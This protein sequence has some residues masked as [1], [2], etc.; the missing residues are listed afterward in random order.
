MDAARG[1]DRRTLLRAGAATAWSVPLVQAATAAPAFAVSGPANLS[2]TSGTISRANGVYTINITVT[3]SG[4]S[5]TQGLLATLT[6]SPA[7]IQSASTPT[8]GLLTEARVGWSGASPTWTADLQI[9]A[10]GTKTFNMTFSVPTGHVGKAN[11]V[12]VTFAT[13]G[14]TSGSYSQSFTQTTSSGTP[15]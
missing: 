5:A 13:T 8:T 14:G 12:T 9:P 1:M 11:T 4:G 3:N 6:S 15:K 7:P 2:T 10:N